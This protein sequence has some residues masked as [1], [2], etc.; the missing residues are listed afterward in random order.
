MVR[1]AVDS[2]NLSAVAYDPESAVLEVE[3][4]SG[5]VY[6]YF[7]VPFFVYQDLC[8]AASKGKYFN[9]H[10]KRAGYPFARIG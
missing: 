4:H 10:V 6:Q 8:D 9:E 3:F 1:T 7:G 2:S 5:G